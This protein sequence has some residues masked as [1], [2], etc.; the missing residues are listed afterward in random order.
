[1]LVINHA[2]ANVRIL[3]WAQGR[4]TGIP[5]G[6]VRYA[7][8]DHQ[9]NHSLELDQDERLLSQ[10]HYYPYGGTAWWATST[11]IEADYK[12]LRFS[13]KERDASGLYYFGYRSG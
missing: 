12:T 7:L 9:G 8:S 6:Q 2:F 11:A 10:E 13:G 5:D 4:P 1:M 3:Q